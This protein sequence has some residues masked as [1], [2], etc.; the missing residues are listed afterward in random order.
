[1]VCIGNNKRRFLD[2]V[3]GRQRVRGAVGARQDCLGVVCKGQNVRVLHPGKGTHGEFFQRD[4]TDQ[5]TFDFVVDIQDERHQ[6]RQAI[7]TLDGDLL[8][9]AGSGRGTEGV[10]SYAKARV[11]A[12]LYPSS[13]I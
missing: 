6:N 11:L 7:G 1:M 3:V 8:S 12:K 4:N 5:D 10:D 13:P 2:D 9:V